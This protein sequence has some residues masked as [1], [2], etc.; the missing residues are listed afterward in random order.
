[1]IKYLEE[2]FPTAKFAGV[3]RSKDLCKVAATSGVVVVQGDGRALPFF[4]GSS[5][6]VLLSATLKHIRQPKVVLAE[7]RRVLAQNGHL[8][9][10]DPTPYGIRLGLRLGHF[11]RR[12][13]ANIWSLR[14]T[15]TTVTAAGFEVVES[16]AYMLAPRPSAVA[17]FAERLLVRLGT[18]QPFLQQALIAR[19]RQ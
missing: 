17:E 5:D 6:V 3:E 16:F 10:L 2:K 18:T 7:C 9:V 4:S 19:K 11:D 8:M 13:L 12:Y 1:M 15:A 14:E